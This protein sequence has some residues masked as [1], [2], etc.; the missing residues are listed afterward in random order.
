MLRACLTSAAVAAVYVGACADPYGTQDGPRLGDDAGVVADAV[1]PPGCDPT[2]SPKDAPLCVDDSFGVFVAQSGND[3]A[4]G[5][6]AAPVRNLA[7][8]LE[9]AVQAGLPRLYIAE[10]TYEVAAE[11]RSP[12]SVYGGLNA[13]WSYSGVK[14]RLAPRKGVALRITGV[15]GAVLVEDVAIEG[16]ADVAVKG[17]SAIALF[18]SESANVTLRN[19]AVRAGPATDGAKG[20]SFSNYSEPTAAKGPDALGTLGGKGV[21]CTC[22]D[23]AT[24][25]G[26]DGAAANG[27]GIS[28]GSS[29]PAVG[30]ANQG[31]SLPV[32]CSPGAIGANGLGGGTAAAVV[33]PGALSA[34]GW[35]SAQTG[36]RAP[37]GRPGQGGGGGGASSNT[38]NGGGAGGCGGCGGASG[39]AGDNGGSSFALLSFQST[40]V[41]SADSLLASDSAGAGGAGADGQP[42]QTEGIGGNGSCKGGL[43]GKGGGGSAGNGGAGGHSSPVA[44]AGPVPQLGN[45]TLTPATAPAKGGAPGA[46]G[47]GA[48]AG[49]AGL[50]G[51]N[52]QVVRTLAL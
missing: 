4:R 15:S 43:G 2:K 8:G 34:A 10:G 12:I 22:I 47:T 37:N 6:K 16:A 21:K 49:S 14:P 31:T 5:T 11:I 48:A 24:S 19:V 28:S 17:D 41:V 3:S 33:S 44:Y 29:S 42:A 25:S 18:V 45:T 26:G 13:A 7:K 35:S 46:V 9:L 39:G 40:V 36:A 1:A 32:G 23:G 50:G 51:P 38:G 27:S 20:A 30:G 52:G